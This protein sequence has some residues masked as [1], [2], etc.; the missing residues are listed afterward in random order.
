MGR[1]LRRETFETDP[2]IEVTFKRIATCIQNFIVSEPAIE[3]IG[4]SVPGLVDAEIGTA[5]FVPHFKWRDWAIAAELQAVTGMPVMVDND[6]NAAALAE[7]WL[8]RP[9]IRDVRDFILVLVEEGLEPESYLTDRFITHDRRSDT[10]A[11]TIGTNAP[12]VCA[13][14]SSECWEAFA[15]NAAP[16]VIFR[17]RPS[18]LAK[19]KV[20]GSRQFRICRSKLRMKRWSKQ[21]TTKGWESPTR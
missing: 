17:K 11:M 9:E 13:A 1:V 20:S 16:H 4:I 6:A 19:H 8:G 12:A 15:S 14:G 10:L 7:L 18:Q 5:L 2:D 3:G 21:R